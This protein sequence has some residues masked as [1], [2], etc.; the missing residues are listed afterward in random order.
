MKQCDQR[1]SKSIAIRPPGVLVTLLTLGL[2]LVSTGVARSAPSGSAATKTSFNEVTGLLGYMPMGIDN[3]SA[4]LDQ[5]YGYGVSWY[6]PQWALT[7]QPVRAQFG[8]PGAWVLPDPK[9]VDA[10]LCP[11]D[12]AKIFNCE[13]YNCIGRFQTIEGGGGAWFSTHFASDAP[14]YRMNGTP[15]CYATEISSPGWGFG[16]PDTSLGCDAMGIAQLSN[17]LVVP[18][19]G[20]TYASGPSNLMMGSAWMNMPLPDVGFF[21]MKTQFLE[22]ENKCL[23][24][25]RV[26][27]G[28]TLGGA[29]FMNTCANQTGQFWKLK[30]VT[31]QSGY[32]WLQT[33]FEGD[34]KCLEGNKLDPSSYLKGAAFMNDCGF[35]TGQFWKFEK[36]GNGYYH[37]KT[38]FQGDSKCLE[39][40]KLAPGSTL[41]GAA[42]MADC[43]NVSGQLWKLEDLVTGSETVPTGNYNWTMFMNTANFKGPVAFY[44]PET[45]SALSRTHGPATGMG[46]DARLGTVTSLAMES[47]AMPGYFAE[48]Q[49]VWYSK[50]PKIGFPT[51]GSKRTVLVQDLNVYNAAALYE[52][53]MHWI[54]GGARGVLPGNFGGSSGRTVPSCSSREINLTQEIPGFDKCKGLPP[55]QCTGECG[56]SRGTCQLRLA[57]LGATSKLF[58]AATCSWGLEWSTP[59]AKLT[60]TG[61]T[62]SFPEYFKFTPGVGMQGVAASDVPAGLQ[63][64][65]FPV[66]GQGA[67]YTSPNNGCWIPS[68]SHA[69]RGPY[70]ATL[71][72]KSEVTYYWYR[73]IDQPALQQL[74]LSPEMKAQMQTLVEAMHEGWKING[75]YFPGPS[76]GNPLVSL[77][78]ALLV[79]PPTGISKGW[80][81]IVTEQRAG[82]P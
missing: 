74:K 25:N 42:F 41:D 20:I 32:F 63:A 1:L 8:L 11:A 34:N 13:G 33:Q 72:D 27:A 60:V 43:Q 12:R 59:S 79:T 71:S 44:I 35:Q 73:F 37:L 48:Q 77:D 2:L 14:K 57:G 55:S 78:S 39:G 21:K 51:H 15:N 23:E 29:S 65:S 10:C 30:P 17:R 68:S 69:R 70:T 62:Q 52:P 66:P 18:P 64:E 38:M 16:H 45:F 82:T 9:G 46:L 75:N 56:N 6:S 40:N 67:A 31:N 28:S 50:I 22:P 49:G 76:N 36:Q 80:V 4:L 7:D 24:G 47:G 3:S 81:P 26:A 58:D 54:Q 53:M 19:D 61:K 5:G